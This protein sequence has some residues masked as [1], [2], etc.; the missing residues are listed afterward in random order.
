[1]ALILLATKLL[2]GSA[3][4]AQVRNAELWLGNINSIDLTERWKFW[5]DYHW[6]SGSFLV[7]RPGLTYQT[8]KGYQLTAGFAWLWLSAPNEPGLP[9]TEN[10]VWGQAVKGWPLGSRWRYSVRLRYDGRFKQALDEQGDIQADWQREFSNRFRLMQNF[11]FALG[12]PR[13]GR[14]WHLDLANEFLYRD[15]PTIDAGIDQI[16]NFVLLGRSGPRLT[17]RAGYHQRWV[18]SASG[19]WTL[20]HGLTVWLSESFHLE[21]H[22]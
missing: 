2:C 9:R 22:P 6:A 10:R 4:L 7:V 14:Q 5:N 21:A 20:N 17:L 16:R 12:S 15:G 18:P 8:A 13:E 3:A 19:Q 1:M 11:R